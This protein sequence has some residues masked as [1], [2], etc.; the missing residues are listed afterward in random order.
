MPWDGKEY[1]NDRKQRSWR[2]AVGQNS[3]QD[4]EKKDE[5]G[6]GEEERWC[7]SLNGRAFRGVEQQ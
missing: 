3:A 7:K 2:S 5:L 6:A 4:I 1:A